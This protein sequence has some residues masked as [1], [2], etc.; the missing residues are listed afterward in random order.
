MPLNLLRCADDRLVGPDTLRLLRAALRDV[1]RAVLLV[2]S[3]AQ[4]L[5]A[6]R[7]LAAAGGLSLGVTVSTPAAWAEERWGVWGDGRRLVGDTARDVLAARVL[8]RAAARPGAPVADTPGTAAL[9]ADLAR[10]GL[11]WLVG[12]P[13][14]EGVTEAEAAVVALLGDYAAELAERGLVEPCEAMASMAAALDAA[15]AAVPPLVLAGVT[16]LRRPERELVC[17]LAATHE[18]TVVAPADAG[19]AAA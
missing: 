6:Q 16:E 1:G 11:P 3:F 8:A 19:P 4:A 10:R 14:P 12:V 5:D 7:E 18:V 15:C 9:L 2:P 17:G 13:A